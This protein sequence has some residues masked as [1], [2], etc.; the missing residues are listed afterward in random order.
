MGTNRKQRSK[1][2]GTFL[3]SV[4]TLLT[5]LSKEVTEIKSAVSEIQALYSFN[6]AH[7]PYWFCE[8]SDLD[9]WQ[10]WEALE[11]QNGFVPPVT[12]RDNAQL[13]SVI[14]SV[15][16][17]PPGMDMLSRELLLQYRHSQGDPWQPLETCTLSIFKSSHQPYCLWHPCAKSTFI[18]PGSLTHMELESDA[19]IVVQKWYRASNVPAADDGSECESDYQ[20]PGSVCG[21]CDCREC[22]CGESELSDEVS[23][24][25]SERDARANARAQAAVEQLAQVEYFGFTKEHIQNAILVVG[26]DDIQGLVQWLTRSGVKPN[27]EIA[28]RYLK[29][30]E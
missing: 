12:P 26:T 13:G 19:A 6:T 21:M 25:G 16:A 3:D 27:P 20:H 7:Q 28:A 17:S 1:S 2:E 9:A 24:S 22:T 29:Q 11:H 4:K 5:Q 10:T 30:Y 15:A 18:Q 23:D 14:G 8:D